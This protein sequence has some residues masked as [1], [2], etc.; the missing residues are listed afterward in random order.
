MSKLVVAVVHHLDADN[1]IS[2]LEERGHRLT[3]IPSVGGFLGI[4]NSTLL[5]GVEDEAL[6]S[7][8]ET[9]D[10]HCSSRE[11]ELPLVLVG[12]LKEQL[13]GLVR[14]GGAT[15]FIADLQEIVRY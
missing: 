8:L 15:V 3:R 14:H 2:A 6:P 5:L 7:V 1:V 4:E 11:I 12:R 10:E 9:I 13:P